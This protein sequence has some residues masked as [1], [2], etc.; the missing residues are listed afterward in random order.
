[1]LVTA[2][3][4]G[5]VCH[6]VFIFQLSPDHDLT[7]CAAKLVLATMSRGI[8]K[9]TTFT[10][11]DGTTTPSSDD[12]SHH[13][14]AHI[15]PAHANGHDQIRALVDLQGPGEMLLDAPGVLPDNV[16]KRQMSWW[17]AAIRNILLKS[18]VH[19]SR[20]LG[21]IQVRYSCSLAV[22]HRA[23]TDPPLFRHLSTA[24]QG[25]HSLAQ[26]VLPVHLCTGNTHVLHDLLATA[27]L[28]WPLRDGQRVR[29]AH[30][31][32]PLLLIA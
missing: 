6:P 5:R 11:H 8:P 30:F 22:V 28:L 2:V 32:L 29:R 21:A 27:I 16:Y 20:I 13:S 12:A 9:I 19:E 17:R 14:S 10:L 25:P 3:G 4:G 7:T 18:L 15:G 23:L 26:Q 24:G 1:M 31:R